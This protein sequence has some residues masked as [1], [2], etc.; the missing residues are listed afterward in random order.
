VSPV[1]P[2]GVLVASSDPNF[3]RLAATVLREAGHVASTS[4]LRSDRL[5]RHL[6]LRSPDVIL[7]D[8]DVATALLIRDAIGQPPVVVCALDE[9]QPGSELPVV[10]KWAAPGALVTAVEDAAQRRG[11]PRLRLVGS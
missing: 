10:G 5:S 3:R 8:A 2:L 7:V 4:D 6:R 11:R 9:P 1:T